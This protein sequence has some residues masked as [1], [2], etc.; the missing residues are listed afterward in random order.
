MKHKIFPSPFDKNRVWS[1]KS[2][3]NY[4]THNKE[5]FFSGLLSI[6][7]AGD[8]KI[9]LEIFKKNDED[10]FVFNSLIINYDDH[11]YIPWDFAESTP[12]YVL[13][14][15]DMLEKI[16]LDKQKEKE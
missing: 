15:C 1:I 12:P 13:Y 6:T 10:D 7:L 16:L 5:W 4:T 2:R 11:G 14:A 3:I 8:Y 9:V